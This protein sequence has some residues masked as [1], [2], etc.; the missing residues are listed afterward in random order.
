MKGA[1]AKEKARKEQAALIAAAK[2]SKK[3][4]R[5][6]AKLADICFDFT[7]GTCNRGD[8]C[9][10]SH[11]LPPKRCHP[12]S[13]QDRGRLLRLHQGHLQARV[14]A[15]PATARRVRDLNLPKYLFSPTTLG[16]IDTPLDPVPTSS[17]ILPSHARTIPAHIA[18][19]SLS[20]GRDACRFSHDAQAV[21]A[22][23]K[24]EEGSSPHPPSS[25][26]GASETTHRPPP[27][28]PG[29]NT[30]ARAYRR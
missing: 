9:R 8:S 18:P 15:P 13:A 11:E 6:D 22:F 26:R 20:L 21:A 4:V 1:K 19:L 12:P 7:R 2:A 23:T 29:A 25:S 10:F 14:R 16:G 5:L 30:S 17:L 24:R 3:S 27:D 28:R